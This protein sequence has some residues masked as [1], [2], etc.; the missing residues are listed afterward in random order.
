MTHTFPEIDLQDYFRAAPARN[1]FWE[2][3][4]WAFLR[5][6]AY[7]NPFHDLLYAFSRKTSQ[8]LVNRS[9]PMR[10]V[11]FTPDR[12]CIRSIAGDTRE[13]P[14]RELSVFELRWNQVFPAGP[15]S[16]SSAPGNYL[17]LVARSEGEEFRI[18]VACTGTSLSRLLRELYDQRVPLREFVN[19]MR[20]FR[21]ATD[22]PYQ[23]IQALK[24]T[25]GISW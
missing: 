4:W 25:Y 13:F 23:R 11:T 16:Y 3:R 24:E 22:I 18:P 14:Y 19:G 17:L 6:D 12:L 9:R 10:K 20:S 21:L 2:V 15:D 8:N 5:G 1:A 7:V